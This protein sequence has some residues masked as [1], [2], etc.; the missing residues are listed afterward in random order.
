MTTLQIEAPLAKT[1]RVTDEELVVALSDGRS[2]TVPL[3]WYPR[4]FHGSPAE[5][6]NMVIEAGGHG[7]HWP[8]LDEDISVEGL[9][10]GRPSKE[11]AKSFQKWLSARVG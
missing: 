2:M 5:R 7:I 8:D 11:S 4:V 3:S 9:V 6:A 10:V 1:V